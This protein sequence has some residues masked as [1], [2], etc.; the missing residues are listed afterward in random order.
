MLR[1]TS[2]RVEP[3]KR[4]GL[5]RCRSDTC[6]SRNA[7]ALRKGAN[8]M[9]LLGSL[10]SRFHASVRLKLLSMVLLPLFVVLP[11]LIGLVL[12]WGSMAYDRLL[13]FKVGSDLV[14]AN[15]Y[16]H[17]VVQSVGS[18]IEN[19][20][21]SRRLDDALAAQDKQLLRKLLIDAK[22]AG[23]FDFLDFVASD[24][25]VLISAADTES[26]PGTRGNRLTWLVV[27]SAVHGQAKTAIDLYSEEQLGAID[28]TLRERAHIQ[29][30]ATKNAAPTES[31]SESRGMLVHAA[32]P[33]L[34][35]EGKVT[36]VLEGGQLLNRNLDFVDNMNNII[37]REDSLPQGSHGTA[38]L[39]LD[40]VRIATNVRLFHGTRALGTRVSKEVSDKVLGQGATWRDRAFVVDDWYVSGYEPI[41]D[42]RGHRVGML[43]VGFLE[44]P[45]REAKV[46]G[47]AAI[48]LLFVMISLAGAVWSLNWARRIF[49]PLER[50]NQTMS[51]VEAGI[52]NARV[53][54]LESRDEIGAL[55]RHFDELLDALQRRNRELENYAGA[56]DVKVAERTAELEAANRS[57]M[58]AQKQLVMSEKL[59][60]IGQLTAGVAHEINNPIA[61]IQGN[62]DLARHVLGAAAEPI[63]GELRLMDAQV[64][65]IR[66][67]VAKLLQFARPA[68][69][70]GY[71]EAVEVNSLVADCLLLVR[72]ELKGGAIEVTQQLAATR[73]AG[74]NRNE[75]QQ[76]MINLLVNAIQAMPN[77][78]VLTIATGDW[79]DKGVV[80]HVRDTGHG[81]AAEDAGR[82]FNAFFTTKK[83]HGTGLGLSISYALV[84]RY[85]GQ[86]TLESEY[87]QGAT[88]TVW[89]MTEPQYSADAA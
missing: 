88:F 6:Q 86:I 17:E 32:A 60:A 89:L 84:E 39:F 42:S 25:N 51:E 75:L 58:D 66:T 82:V 78:G 28:I 16:F 36:G 43:Y 7:L 55:A 35:R 38:T 46:I 20:A 9:Q 2:A 47:L 62:L 61:V 1:F 70:A 15:R 63:M 30:L 48:V 21:Q 72:H 14:I 23:G 77:G 52:A 4:R 13:I 24:G 8:R 53:G 18:N 67:I 81:V 80:I 59:A 26:I 71:V 87:G 19:L 54:R 27:E 79:E 37:Y 83:Q 50:M 76:V 10:K 31:T 56:L 57:L 49:Q 5:I 69:F 40:D 65:R 12:Y 74:I 22:T 64:N 44:A 34:D 45:F 73:S 29:L 85:G 3:Q 68:D 41:L 11:I 33:V